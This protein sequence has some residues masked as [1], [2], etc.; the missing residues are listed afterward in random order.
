MK[1]K[2]AFCNNKAQR[3]ALPPADEW[4]SL[5]SQRKLADFLEMSPTTIR[6][7]EESGA[8]KAIRLHGRSRKVFTRDAV[9]AWLATGAEER[10]AAR[11]QEAQP[12]S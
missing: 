12:D 8:L 2:G 11:N 3:V 7:A 9:S 10:Y 5:F 4:P 6:K 1:H